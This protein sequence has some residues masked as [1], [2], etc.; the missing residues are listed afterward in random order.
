MDEITLDN[1]IS[2]SNVVILHTSNG[3]APFTCVEPVNKQH[4]D[5]HHEHAM[6]ASMMMGF[7]AIMI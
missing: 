5:M 2:V 7:E 4:W 6:D 1:N 3:I